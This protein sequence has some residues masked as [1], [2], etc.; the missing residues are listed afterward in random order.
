MKYL[1]ALFFVLAFVSFS[2]PAL[3]G[4][5]NTCVADGGDT[6]L[7]GG[8]QGDYTVDFGDHGCKADLGS[9]SA[10]CCK[11][12][13]G[14][15]PAATCVAAG[16]HCFKTNPLCPAGE[17]TAGTFDCPP[18]A[19]SCCV[20]ES[21]KPPVS[22][23]PNVTAGFPNKYNFQ[24]PFQGADVNKIVN[25]IIS[26]GLSLVG[27]L[28]FVMFLWGGVTWMTAGGEAKRVESASKTLTNAV[29]G[30]IIVAMAYAIVNQIATSISAGQQGAPAAQAPKT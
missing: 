27:A 18:E 5:P 16:G 12:Q 10:E 6:C 28:F 3:A 11:K 23:A 7:L 2:S 26:A 24:D 30:L 1:S 25:N 8:C 15:P 17:G 19:N 22:A 9:P 13:A 14:A 20:P 4:P 21:A 29:I